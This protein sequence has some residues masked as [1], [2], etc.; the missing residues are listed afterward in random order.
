MQNIFKKKMMDTENSGVMAAG[1]G[2]ASHS[3]Q[4]PDVFTFGVSLPGVEYKH[5][6]CLSVETLCPIHSDY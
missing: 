4:F 3:L 6:G 5:G 1:R 2:R